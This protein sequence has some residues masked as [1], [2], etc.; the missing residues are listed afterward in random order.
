MSM[1]SK[2][3]NREGSAQVC[4]GGVKEQCPSARKHV[5]LVLAE[6]KI[7][8]FTKMPPAEKLLQKSWILEGV[9]GAENVKSSLHLSSVLEQFCR[10]FRHKKPY[11]S[12]HLSGK[13]IL[14]RFWLR[15]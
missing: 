5:F 3:I 4:P 1:G 9:F 13:R 10:H 14:A 11:F 12:T 6:T 8:E 2:N 7:A 15:L